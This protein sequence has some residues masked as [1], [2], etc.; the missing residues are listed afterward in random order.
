MPHSVRIVTPMPTLGALP[1]HQLPDA[2]HPET[3]A[4]EHGTWRRVIGT[5]AIHDNGHLTYQACIGHSLAELDLLRGHVFH[6]HVNG[7]SDDWTRQDGF[8]ETEVSAPLAYAGPAQPK[9]AATSAA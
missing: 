1:A 4:D 6:S 9:P 5:V 8:W 3:W 7:R 2:G